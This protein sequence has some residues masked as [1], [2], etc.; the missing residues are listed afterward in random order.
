MTPA[1]IL[2]FTLMTAAP[3]AGDPGG[4][5]PLPPGAPTDSYELSAWCYG[6]LDEY[7]AIYDRVKPDLRDIDHMFGTSVVEDEPYQSDMA[8]A[9]DELKMIGDAVTDAEKASPRPIAERGAA[10]MRQGESIWSLAEAKPQRELARAWMLWALPDACDSNARELMTRS[11]ILGRALSY[12]A[13]DPAQL[14]APSAPRVAPAPAPTAS[15]LD[16]ANHAPPP[17]AA[18]APTPAPQPSAD[19]VDLPATDE[20]AAPAALLAE[21]V[22]PPAPAPQPSADL[23]A[24]PATAQ[25]AAAQAE[26]APPLSAPPEAASVQPPSAPPAVATPAAV[27]PPAPTASQTPAHPPA[28]PASEQPQEPT[29]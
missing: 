5:E 17:A 8:A 27:P 20:A 7:L 1:L 12:N 23:V 18:E 2:A 16:A 14:P 10:A 29:L 6:A 24:S 21:P 26:A 9:R 25:A 22:A 13:G 19:L 4:G 28:G 11:L 3:A 15:A